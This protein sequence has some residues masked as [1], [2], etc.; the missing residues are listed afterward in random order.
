MSRRPLPVP[1]LLSY[2][3]W[4]AARRHQLLYVRCADCGAAQFP[5]ELACTHCLSAA[6]AW[7]PATGR[8]TLYSYTVIH[9]APFPD[10][11]VPAVMALVVL[12]EGPALFS[13]VVGCD[14]AD[15]RCDMALEVTFAVQ[16]EATTLPVFR[17]AGGAEEAAP[18]AR[19]NSR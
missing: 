11:P 1:T 9:R 10:F 13:A 4:D 14:P 17:P 12:E 5:L 15:L 18:P 2:E 19:W 16:D 7:V 6:V 8:A 3:Y